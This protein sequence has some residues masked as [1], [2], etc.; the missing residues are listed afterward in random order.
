M[1]NLAVSWYINPTQMIFM[2]LEIGS[3]DQQSILGKMQTQLIAEATCDVAYKS[4]QHVDW[5]LI[6]IQ[7]QNPSLAVFVRA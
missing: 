2:A 3:R 7:K 6:A 5:K 4:L 1:A